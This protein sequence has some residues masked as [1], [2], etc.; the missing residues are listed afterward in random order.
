MLWDFTDDSIKKFFH[1]WNIQA[2]LAWNL[3]RQTHTYIVED[4]LCQDLVSLQ[5]QVYGRFPKFIEILQNSP[6][7]EVRFLVQ[8]VQDDP[9]SRTNAN[10]Q[11]LNSLTN[12]DCLLMQHFRWKQTLPRE[13]VPPQENWRVRW[14]QLLMG[15]Q[16]SKDYDSLN[17]TKQQCE[18]MLMSV[19]IT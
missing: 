2:R 11:F 17:L 8:L 10:V 15:V 5:N 18:E 14:I 6:S 4:L 13:T 16:Q 3:H 1:A 12:D 9:K 19:C 7:K